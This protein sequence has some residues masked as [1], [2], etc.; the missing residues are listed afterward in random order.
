MSQIYESPYVR[1]YVEDGILY[2]IY[3]EGVHITLEVART[4]V[5]E[6]VA[7]QGSRVMPGMIFLQEIGSVDP[8]AR[9]YLGT[10]EASKNINALALVTHS[11]FMNIIS[12]MYIYFNRPPVPVK[13]FSKEQ[14]GLKW[15]QQ[16]KGKG[17]NNAGNTKAERLYAF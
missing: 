8:D 9:A 1:L 16:F 11:P 15:L 14:D 3:K 2:G 4:I 17:D 13:L 6:R 10:P 7:M 5:R 12:N